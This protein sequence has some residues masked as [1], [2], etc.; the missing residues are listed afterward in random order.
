VKADELLTI[1]PYSLD[2]QMKDR[3]LLGAISEELQFHYES[4]EPYRK[5]LDKR[6]FHVTQQMNS[7]SEVPY[8]P[9][10]IFKSADLTSVSAQDVVRTVRSS[11]TTSQ[12]PSKIA[13]DRVTSNRQVRALTLILR[14]V[15]GDQRLPFLVLDA[16]VARA[17]SGDGQLTARSAAIRGFLVAASE[18]H[19]LLQLGS[20]NELCVDIDRVVAETE[21]LVNESKKFVFFGFTYVIHKA[22]VSELRKRGIRLAAANAFVLHIGG[23]KKLQSEAVSKKEFNRSVSETF[24]VPEANVIDIYGFTEQLGIIYPDHPNGLKMAPVFSD[25]IVRDPTTLQPR[26]DGEAGLLQFLTPLPHSY[27]GN[28]II[29]DDIGRIVSRAHEGTVFEVL[30]RAHATEMRGCGDILGLTMTIGQ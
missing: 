28:S 30:G 27:P 19:H 6:G 20:Q 21:R 11:A 4:C 5:W 17:N 16:D 7:L 15:L 13:L 2:P 22:V 14:H 24:G 9:V 23:W 25:V 26:P 12:I 8:L 18:A 1:A 10:D 3:L 29:L